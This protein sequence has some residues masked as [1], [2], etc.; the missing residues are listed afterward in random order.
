LAWACIDV[1]SNTTR[2]LVAEPAGAGIRELAARREFTRIGKGLAHDGR[3]SAEVVAHAARAVAD[4]ARVAR[5][6]GAREIEVVGTAAMRR[7]R[8]RDELAS[9]IEQGCGVR[10]RV[11]SDGEEARLAFLG[12][13][14]TYDAPL[15][16]S[17]AVVDVGG[18]S[19]EIAVGTLGDGVSWSTSVPIGSGTLAE[20]LIGFDPPA[21]DELA[22]LR[23]AVAT[24]L[25]GL[26]VPSSQNAIAVGGSATSLR[27]LAGAELSVEALERA[28]RTLASAP[29]DDLA[30]L[31]G[32]AAER[33]RLLPAGI[34]ILE[35]LA[36]ALGT[37]LRIGRGGLREGLILER[38]ARSHS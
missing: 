37:P 21:P 5:E 19:S 2:L 3:V 34:A 20:E 16:G 32:L 15:R 26:R 6:L 10:M 30:G 38:S 9:A 22:A 17:V 8:N 36:G 4:Q 25:E 28:L 13:T 11:L 29:A 27:R 35:G 24:A 31:L 14:R 1:G 23:A 12:A 18:G 33:V 7:A